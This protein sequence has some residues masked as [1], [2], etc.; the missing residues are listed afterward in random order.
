MKVLRDTDWRPIAFIE[1][2]Q[3]T[4]GNVFIFRNEKWE[5]MAAL[6]VAKYIS[7][8]A[9]VVYFFNA[10]RGEVSC[11]GHSK[12]VKVKDFITN[13]QIDWQALFHSVRENKYSR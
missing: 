11:S 13:G 5:D 6:N 10:E 2:F 7:T 12:P 8:A 1:C 3:P 9:N 4:G